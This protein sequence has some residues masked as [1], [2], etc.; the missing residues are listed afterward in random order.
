MKEAG[1]MNET[2][3][4]ILL[5]IGNGSNFNIQKGPLMSQKCRPFLCNS[6]PKCIS[7]SKLMSPYAYEAVHNF[8]LFL[9]MTPYSEIIDAPEGARG[10]KFSV[11]IDILFR[12][13]SKKN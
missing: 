1:P 9:K 7:F 2:G 13:H 6:F 11:Y 10:Q 3:A 5:Y 8:G 4:P 12:Y